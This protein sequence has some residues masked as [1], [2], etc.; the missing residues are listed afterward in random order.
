MARDGFVTIK[1]ANIFSRNFSG[2]E[3]QYNPAGRRNFC[4]FIDDLD[5]ADRMAA[6]GWNIRYLEP[7]EEGEPRRAFTQVAVSF[8]NIPPKVILVTKRGQTPLTEEEINMLDYAEITNVDM[9]INPSRWEVAGKSG[10][11]GYLRSIYVTIY[12][13]ELDELYSN[14]PDSA[15]SSLADEAIPFD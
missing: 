10:I 2:K 6:D 1:N 13:D 11:K 3:G 5:V 12:E 9:T 15:V 7:R 8:K 14:V 4:V